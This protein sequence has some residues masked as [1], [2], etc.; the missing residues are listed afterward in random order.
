MKKLLLLAVVT[1]MG[2]TASAQTEKGSFVLGGSIGYY[3][4][5]YTPDNNKLSSFNIAPS[6]GYFVAD[7]IA[8]GL[9]LGYW[10]AK[11]DQNAGTINGG[12]LRA[13]MKEELFS[14]R[15][16]VRYYKSVSD[17]FKFF[18]NLQVPLSFGNIKSSANYPGT[19]TRKTNAVGA[20]FSPGFAYFPTPK[21]GIEFSVEGITYNDTSYD[22]ESNTSNGHT[23]QFRIG[24]NLMSPL[25][26]VQYYF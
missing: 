14:I 1:V 11:Y 4:D 9:G 21:L 5:K 8:V 18:G 7:N 10:Q 20:S 24:A 17:Q 15:P 13:T 3:K 19:N 23:K 25:I 12:A 6:A 22:Y 16:F 2:L 26:G